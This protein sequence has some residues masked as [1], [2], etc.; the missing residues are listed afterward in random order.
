MPH[1]RATVLP[2]DPDWLH[3]GPTLRLLVRGVATDLFTIS[4]MC[5]AINRT[6]KTVRLLIAMG[7]LPD[8]GHRSPGRTQQGQRRLWTRQEVLAAAAVVEELKLL[9]C[10]PQAWADTPLFE[11]ISARTATA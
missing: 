7:M 9:N 2:D 11:L 3:K 10:R 4:A 1:E 5:R 6:P 8:A